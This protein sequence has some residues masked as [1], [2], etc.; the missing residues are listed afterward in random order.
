MRL[1]GDVDLSHK[2]NFINFRNSVQLRQM[3]RQEPNYKSGE[4]VMGKSAPSSKS[5]LWLNV[6]LKV[7][8]LEI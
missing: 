6:S 4:V 5:S 3:S 7:H 8:E 2:E 1:L